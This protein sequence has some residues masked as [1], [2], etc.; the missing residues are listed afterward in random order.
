MG[1]GTGR[2]A[3]MSVAQWLDKQHGF[4]FTH[5]SVGIAADS[6][7]KTYRQ[8]M[9]QILS[10][11]E[12]IVG[13]I[14]PW[15]CQHLEMVF[16]EHPEAKV[17]YVARPVAEVVKSFQTYVGITKKGKTGL[18]GWYPIWEDE[19]SD[20]AVF[21]A[22]S[23]QAWLCEV[24][25]MQWPRKIMKVHLSQINDVKVQDTILAWLGVK[26]D[27]RVY[28]IERM[29]TEKERVEAAEHKLLQSEQEVG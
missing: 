25:C 20:D 27:Y 15:W 4:N 28:G 1:M 7:F 14:S 9:N 26:K 3:S 23:R 10:R 16:E 8:A 18:W 5:E 2:N 21:R 12:P 11:D 6:V 29:N 19:Y 22:V 17:L 13:D 24:A